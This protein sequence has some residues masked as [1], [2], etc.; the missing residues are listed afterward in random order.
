MEVRS[1]SQQCLHRSLLE[2]LSF[3]SVVEQLST[4]LCSQSCFQWGQI[5]HS[6]WLRVS[7][8]FQMSGLPSD[9]NEL[10]VNITELCLWWK[11]RSR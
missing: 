10:A 11:R 8:S 3:Q 6:S 7:L 2:H 4:A 9:V 1:A 5:P